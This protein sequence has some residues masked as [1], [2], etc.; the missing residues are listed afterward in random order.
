M[1]R[2][3]AWL[4]GP[5]AEVPPLLQPVAQALLQVLEDVERA[6]GALP[7]EALWETPNG[8]ASIGFHLHHLAGATDR[9]LTYA[10]GDALNEAQRARAAGEA[11]ARPAM[12]ADQLLTELRAVIDS[13]LAQLRATPV[14]LLLTPRLIGRARLPTTVLGCLFHAAEHA[15]RHAGQVVTTAKQVARRLTDDL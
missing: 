2:P 6:A 9:L 3:D 10:R 15:A 11:E 13:A 7:R 5:V 1:G 12:S 14:E 8:A 4:R